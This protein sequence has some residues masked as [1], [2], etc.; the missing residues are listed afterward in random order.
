MSL[1]DLLE[2]IGRAKSGTRAIVADQFDAVNA[3]AGGLITLPIGTMIQITCASGKSL[4]A[5]AEIDGRL[6]PIYLFANHYPMLALQSC[7]PR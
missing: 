1:L 5:I 4:S 6:V 7:K 3:G 2:T